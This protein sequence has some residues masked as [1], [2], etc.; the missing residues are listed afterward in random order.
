MASVDLALAIGPSGFNRLVVL[1]SLLKEL[2]V[3][4]DTQRMFLEEARI[5]ARLNHPNVVQVS[6]VIEAPDG[7]ILVMEYLDGMPLSAAYR[8]ANQFLTLAMRLRLV[9]EALAGLHYAHELS[10]FHGEA[11]GIVH[12]DVSPQNIFVTYDGRIKLLDFGIAKAAISSERTRAGLIK[13]RIAYM[14]AEQLKGGP[15]DRRTD[16]YAVGCLLWEAIAGQRLWAD[17]SERDIVRSVLGGQI[18]ALSSRLDVDPRL[19]AIVA[20]ATSLEANQRYSTAEEMRVELERELSA[21]TPA[22][23]TR[24]I[25]EVLSRLSSEARENRQSAIAAAIAAVEPGTGQEAPMLATHAETTEAGFV[26]ASAESVSARPT[27]SDAPTQVAKAS[28][29]F[30][31]EAT[32]GSVVLAAASLAAI[33]AL[34]W[35]GPLQRA[36]IA[37]QSFKAELGAPIAPP[38]P[39]KTSRVV[40]VEASR[41]AAAVDP[42][43]QAPGAASSLG[44]QKAAARARALPSRDAR[45]APAAPT[46]DMDVKKSCDPPFFFANGNKTYKPEC[47]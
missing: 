1:K 36:P 42:A 5:S 47:I 27:P 37:R 24:D 19:E 7:A 12:R 18:P 16:I 33:A 15:V 13:G 4:D 25:G 29:R 10:D 9:C 32:R 43:K 35:P 6:E 31:A 20:K 30:R 17:R 21:L 40:R 11:L 8:V 46:Q 41:R 3:R 26:L 28:S 38:P 34:V 45:V 39:G 2:S 23:A 22:M 44:T 14:P